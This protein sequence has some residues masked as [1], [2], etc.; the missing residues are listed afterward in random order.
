MSAN[1]K[2]PGQHFSPFYPSAP[3]PHVSSCS[4][5][6]P[7]I[8]LPFGKEKEPHSSFSVTAPPPTSLAFHPR[9]FTPK[10]IMCAKF[11][12]HGSYSGSYSVYWLPTP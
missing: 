10:L 7:L 4:P 11:S 3:V 2:L 12:V 1:V 5:G 8:E 6:L 9:C